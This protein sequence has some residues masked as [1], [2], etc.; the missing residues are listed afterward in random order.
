MKIEGSEDRINVHDPHLVQLLYTPSR[1]F[2]YPI[3]SHYPV[4]KYILQYLSRVIHRVWR[5]NKVPRESAISSILPSIFIAM[6]APPSGV[7]NSGLAARLTFKISSHV[8]GIGVTH[9]PWTYK[10]PAPGF[11]SSFILFVVIPVISI[12]RTSYRIVLYRVV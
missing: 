11:G 8:T 6:P 9:S 4:R 3:H 12:N 5:G 10:V 7:K 2:L 1:T